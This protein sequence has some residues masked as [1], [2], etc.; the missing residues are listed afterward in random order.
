MTPLVQS[1]ATVKKWDQELCKLYTASGWTTAAIQLT[2]SNTGER[3]WPLV[4]SKGQKS[5]K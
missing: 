1:S 2:R 3:E 4:F 5:A